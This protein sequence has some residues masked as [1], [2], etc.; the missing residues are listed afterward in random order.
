MILS[1]EEL[2]EWDRDGF[3]VVP[4]AVG[5]AACD[6]LRTRANEIVAELDASTVSIFST[7]EQTRTSDEHFLGSGDQVRCFF[8]AGAFD[9]DGALRAPN[10]QSINKLGHAMHDLDPVFDR[11]SRAPIFAGIAADIGVR[12][13]RLLQSMYIFKQPHF[14]GEVACHQDATFLF[15]EPQTAVGFWVALEDATIHNGCLWAE[16]GGHRGPLRQRFVRDGAGGTRFDLLDPT[17]LPDPASARLVPLETPKGTLVLLHG[18]LPHWSDTNRSERSRHA[19]S[20][21]LIEASAT[22]PPDNWLQRPTLP[23]RGF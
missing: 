12:D 14:G 10:E 23:L 2:A 8:E 20:L 6:E 11:F 17:P 22:Y 15:T 7:D 3:L 19:Y 1:D 13:P 21:H 9:D 16:P 18:L 4:G 5:A